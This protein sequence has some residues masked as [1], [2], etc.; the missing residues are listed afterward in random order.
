[1]DRCSGEVSLLDTMYV[2]Y[3]WEPGVVPPDNRY[4]FAYTVF[5]FSPSGRYLYGVSASEMSQWDLEAED[6]AGSKLVLDHPWYVGWGVNNEWVKLYPQAVPIVYAPDG[7][8]YHMYNETHT[9][10]AHPDER[11]PDCGLCGG[12]NLEPPSCLGSSYELFSARYPNYRLGPLAGS[13]CDT[14][15]REPEPPSGPASGVW[16]VTVFPNPGWGEVSVEVTLP[17]YASGRAQLMVSDVLGRIL[18]KHRFPDYAYMHTLDV[19]EWAAGVYFVSLV[20]GR[21]VVK[22]VKLVVVR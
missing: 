2:G 4:F 19:S 11:C 17:D 1:F 14:L 10:I 7:R 3:H 15:P 18:E 12:W 13:P 9:V 22:T 5:Q 21:E 20:W 6:P 16:D 8:L